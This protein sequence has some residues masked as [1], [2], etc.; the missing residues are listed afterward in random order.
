ME[1]LTGVAGT[2]GLK[3]LGSS[4]VIGLAWKFAGPKIQ[5]WVVSYAI[6]QI[7]L[8]MAGGGLNDPDY[9]EFVA[10][11]AK[12][13]IHLAER[14]IPASGA[15]AERKKWVSGLLSRWF[16][17]KTTDEVSDLIENILVEIAAKAP[18]V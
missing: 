12:A 10:A 5:A 3:V 9:K 16:P 8:A 4:L 7:S 15:G 2:L 1:W 13:V 18:K 6:K 11:V 14:K 17:A